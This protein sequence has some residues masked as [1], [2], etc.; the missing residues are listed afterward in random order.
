MITTVRQFW[1]SCNC[2]GSFTRRSFKFLTNLRQSVVPKETKVKN[3][4]SKPEEKDMII[5]RQEPTNY[6]RLISIF[7]LSQFTMWAFVSVSVFQLRDVPVDQTLVNSEDMPFWKKINFGEAKYRI[8][9]GILSMTLGYS[10]LM[11]GWFYIFRSIQYI[12]LRKGKTRVSFVTHSPFT[13]NR[14][15]EYPI[16]KVSAVG[17]RNSATSMMPIQIQGKRFHYIIDIKKGYFPHPRLFDQTVGLQ[18]RF[19]K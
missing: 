1:T 7:C 9:A 6:Y 3:V 4:D 13:K 14:I 8:T 16:E 18:R 10:I 11:A 2:N 5:Y 17:S 12:V 15:N 19:Q